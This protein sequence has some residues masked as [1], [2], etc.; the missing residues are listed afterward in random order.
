MQNTKQAV[1]ILGKQ[2]YSLDIMDVN[3]IEKPIPVEPVANVPKNIKG[4]IRLRGDVIPIYSLRRKFGMEEIQPD[5]DTRFIITNSNGL[6]IAYEVD[7]M[8]EILQV[9]E[10]EVF[11]VPPIIKSG[12]TSYIKAVANNKGRLVMILDQNS[13][14]TED[15]QNRIKTVINK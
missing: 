14:L 8:T 11:E 3:T 6:L 12:D 1:F 10:G 4:I 5:L 9:E 2:E 7:K 13:I 15:E